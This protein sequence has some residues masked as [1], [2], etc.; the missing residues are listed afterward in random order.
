MCLWQTTSDLSKPNKIARPKERSRL[1]CASSLGEEVA[2]I[3]V[4][5]ESIEDLVALAIWQST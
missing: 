1:T 3:I 4:N 2:E 5:K